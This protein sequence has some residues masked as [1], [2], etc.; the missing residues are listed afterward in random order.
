[1]KLQYRED[2]L[3]SKHFSVPCFQYTRMVAESPTPEECARR[4]GLIVIGARKVG[5]PEGLF[6]VF[7][8]GSFDSPSSLKLCTFPIYVNWA[9]QIQKT[10]SFYSQ[11]LM[12]HLGPNLEADFSLDHRAQ[13]EPHWAAPG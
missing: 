11:T 1:M 8:G 7:G 6:R 10:T 12:K 9:I 5:A 4:W 3:C 2:L 13:L